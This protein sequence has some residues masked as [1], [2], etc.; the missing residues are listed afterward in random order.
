VEL[1]SRLHHFHLVP[2]VGYCIEAHGSDLER[3][4]VYEYMPNGNLRE[5]LNQSF[6][7]ES[8]GWE[9]RLK[10]ALGAARGLEYLHEAA[11]PRVLHRDFK[12]NNILLDS[13]W[14]AKVGLLC[15]WRVFM[16]FD[17]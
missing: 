1:L 10:I 6:R 15:F 14:R 8:L 13:N 7:K 4:L 17:Q 9:A 2:L 11:N 3:L 5:H 16:Q 12:S